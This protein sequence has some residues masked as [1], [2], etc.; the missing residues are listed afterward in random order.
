ME[1]KEDIIESCKSIIHFL[2]NEKDEKVRQLK[3]KDFMH[4]FEQFNTPKNVILKSKTKV[5][6]IVFVVVKNELKAL[7]NLFA[8]TSDNLSPKCEKLNGIKAWEIDINRNRNTDNLHT[9]FVFIGEAGDLECS[10]ATMRVFQEFDCDLAVL[11][12]IAAGLEEEIKKYSVVVSRGIIDYEPQ[13]LLKNN[14]IE[15]RP[16][17]YDLDNKTIRDISYFETLEVEWKSLYKKNVEEYGNINASEFDI[18]YVENAELKTGIIASGKKLFAGDDSLPTLQKF[19][20]FKKGI[21]AAEMESSG[22]CIACKEYSIKWLVIRGISDYGGDDKNNKNNKKY[23]HIAALG[24]FAALTY[25]L[26][27][28]YSKDIEPLG[29]MDNF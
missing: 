23:Q 28:L 4:K 10:I 15:Y 27:N 2:A 1:K 26:Q 25:Y 29:S 6:V 19:L 12:G 20:T 14:E 8:L 3:Y 11:C 7:K 22:F 24:A 21:I 9:L 5:D 18:S 13:K 17:N 16:N